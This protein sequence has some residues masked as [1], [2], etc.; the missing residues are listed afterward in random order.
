MFKPIFSRLIIL[1]DSK[2]PFE[3]IREVIILLSK[4]AAFP[5]LK[6]YGKIWLLINYRS[7]NKKTIKLTLK[8]NIHSILSI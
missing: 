3:I 1:R 7:I 5:I 2:L 8:N 4:A 6:K